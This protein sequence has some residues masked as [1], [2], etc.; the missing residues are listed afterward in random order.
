METVPWSIV[1]PP[2]VYGPGEKDFLS[3]FRMVNNRFAPLIGF[4]PKSYSLVYSE[5]L[6]SG[7]LAVA[8]SE[9]A[10]GQAYFVADPEVH[11]GKELLLAMEEA[12]GKTSW[13][14]RLPEFLVLGLAAAN[15]LIAP[16]LP[17]PPILNL[18]KVKELLPD[19]W[20][21]GTD[22]LRK[23]VGYVCPTSLSKGIR[24]TARWYQK[25]GW[26]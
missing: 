24:D 13:K 5:D 3:M 10:I 15:S 16:F 18:Q 25:K 1:R 14:P 21:V 6:V 8:C 12:L 7:I 2:G 20:V 26:L 11:S 17:K 23:E 9:E 4:R 22:K 19:R